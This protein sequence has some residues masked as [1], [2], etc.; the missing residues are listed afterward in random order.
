MDEPTP[1]V[2]RETLEAEEKAKEVPAETAKSSETPM[3][4]MLSDNKSLRSVG[5]SKKES[6][7]TEEQVEEE[8]PVEKTEEKPAEIPNV[9]EEKKEEE[10]AP[11]APPTPVESTTEGKDDKAAEEAVEVKKEEEEKETAKEEA[12]E[13]EDIS[14]E[15]KRETSKLKGMFKSIKKRVS[16]LKTKKSSK[17]KDAPQEEVQEPEPNPA[18]PELDVPK[19]VD[20]SAA[21][22]PE[23][24]E[25]KEDT[26]DEAAENEEIIKSLRGTCLS[27]E[28]ENKELKRRMMRMKA[29]LSGEPHLPFDERVTD[30][31]ATKEFEN[32]TPDEKIKQLDSQ[33]Q[34]WQKLY[35][36]SNEIG[37]SRIE[38]LEEGC[39]EVS[40]MA[41]ST[42]G[43]THDDKESKGDNEDRILML[44]YQLRESVKVLKTAQKKMVAQHEKEFHLQKTVDD[45]SEQINELNGQVQ[46]ANESEANMKTQ[47][48]EE[49][50]NKLEA[51][52]Q[53]AQERQRLDD[54]REDLGLAPLYKNQA[55][56]ADDQVD[57]QIQQTNNSSMFCWGS[58]A[59]PISQ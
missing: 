4:E 7:A 42:S 50:K 52:A 10:D 56:V 17:N 59:Q 48:E 2:I 23:T 16:K 37:P 57:Q 27:L 24:P 13:V 32:M 18:D 30:T 3:D 31:L 20:D 19:L 1:K 21:P 35:L 9:E 11:V 8:K 53:L 15:A 41:R 39:D 44:E 38:K 22:A 14:E 34:K 25:D 54:F 55:T 6:P 43:N 46:K 28:E 47:W 58:S 5:S 29:Q 49:Q 45:L 51:E 12:A 40:T 26:D 36:E 33:V